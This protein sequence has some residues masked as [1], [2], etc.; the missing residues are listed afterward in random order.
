MGS[1]TESIINRAGCESIFL[2]SSE[3]V[4]H[5]AFLCVFATWREIHPFELKRFT[6]RRKAQRSAKSTPGHYAQMIFIEAA[7]AVCYKL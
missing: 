6:Q 4:A 1:L 2:R 5:F 3:R 7:T